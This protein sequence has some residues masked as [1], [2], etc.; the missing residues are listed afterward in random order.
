MNKRGKS[1]TTTTISPPP[2]HCFP[3]IC[4][5]TTS[6]LHIKKLLQL[7]NQLPLVLADI[8]P[9]ELLECIDTLSANSRV[10]N[11]VFFQVASVHGLVAAFDLDGDGGLTPLADLHGFVVTLNGSTVRRVSKQKTRVRAKR[12][13]TLFLIE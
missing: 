3:N 8:T 13:P 11:I 2:L 12:K 10:E 6:L 5:P 4:I 9:K 1:Y 7:Y